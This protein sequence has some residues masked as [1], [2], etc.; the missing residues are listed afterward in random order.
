VGHAGAPP[1]DPQDVRRSV[2]QA[3]VAADTWFKSV[4]EGSPK[5]PSPRRHC[6]R[7]TSC[8]SPFDAVL[9]VSELKR[10][11]ASRR[12]GHAGL[13]SDP[14]EKA[15]NLCCGRVFKGNRAVFGGDT[16]VPR[17][18]YVDSPCFHED[19]RHPIEGRLNRE[20]IATRGRAA[21]GNLTLGLPGLVPIRIRHRVIAI[22]S[23]GMASPD[24]A[25]RQPCALDRPMFL[26]RFQ[27]IGGTG[28]LITAVEPDPGAEDQPVGPNRQGDD[29]GKR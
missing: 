18:C 20:V 5:T 12:L 8:D 9:P 29:M 10:I 24:P 2:R 14:S 17:R 4:K 13:P 26:Q 22:A 15:L 3:F 6:T 27:R 28:G 19:L 23:K 11:G 1:Q 21:L 16:A 7:H 25:R